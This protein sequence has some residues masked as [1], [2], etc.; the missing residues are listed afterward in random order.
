MKKVKVELLKEHC[1]DG[2]DHKAG[3]VIELPEDQAKWLIEV[4]AAK[5]VTDA[6]AKTAATVGAK[7]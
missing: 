4:K 1:N 3:D 5:T 7:A 2:R 6:P